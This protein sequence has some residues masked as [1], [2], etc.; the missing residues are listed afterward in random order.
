VGNE[1]AGHENEGHEASSEENNASACDSV[2]DFDTFLLIIFWL[3]SIDEKL[4]ILCN[5]SLTFK[6]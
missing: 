2:L 5:I 4:L 3:C 6:K 1:T